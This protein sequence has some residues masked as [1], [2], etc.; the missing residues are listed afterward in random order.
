VLE[1]EM[2]EM[3]RE[4]RCEVV[5]SVRRCV[6]DMLQTQSDAHGELEVE[7]KRLG[8]HVTGLRQDVAQVTQKLTDLL[9]LTRWVVITVIL[10][11]CENGALYLN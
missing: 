2:E 10:I 4:K 6:A 3:R 1:A 5:E 9:L 8:Q 11:V 7:V